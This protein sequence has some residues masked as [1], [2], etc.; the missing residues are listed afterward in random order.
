MLIA[1]AA[2]LDTAWRLPA[3]GKGLA[4]HYG[5]WAMFATTPIIILLTSMLARAFASKI[6]A[7]DSYCVTLSTDVR[8]RL[9]ALADEHV[10]S[11]LLKTRTRSIFAFV[12]I[13]LCF[14]WLLN[15]IATL[16]P[17]GTYHH[18][19]VDAF[20]HRWSY[21]AVRVYTL[22]VFGFVYAEAVFVS[23]HVTVSMFGILRYVDRHDLLKINFFHQD[24][25]AGTS[26]FG[27]INLLVLAVYANWF[28]VIYA[29]YLTHRRPYLVML[30]SLGSC[31]LLA[32][33]QSVG[34]VYYIHR[35]ISR[36]RRACLRVLAERLT[37]DGSLAMESGEPF[38]SD[39]LALRTHLLGV[40]TYPYATGTLLVVNAIR[41]TPAA[42]AVASLFKFP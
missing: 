28:T 40:H 7:T 15:A 31:S 2:S 25:C 27:R 6:G 33:V 20:S 10:R 12:I 3:D 21:V 36:K 30:A 8:R 1:G 11:L 5:L 4:Q 24:N 32:A 35:T 38:R 41:L 23:V 26:M 39:L 18:D 34:A 37:R 13:A 14:W 42:L 22:F 9:T 17:V 16:S 19:V 29:M